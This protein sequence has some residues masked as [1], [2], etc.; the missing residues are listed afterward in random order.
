MRGY[1]NISPDI[2]DTFTR[3]VFTGLKFNHRKARETVNECSYSKFHA[4]IW[5][6][7][8]IRKF[9]LRDA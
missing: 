7:F 4:C 3:L 5:H 1:K 9:T 8:S 2:S 6:Y